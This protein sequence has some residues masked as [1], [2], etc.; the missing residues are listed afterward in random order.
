[1]ASQMMTLNQQVKNE[2][3]PRE[4]TMKVKQLLAK[5]KVLNQDLMERIQGISS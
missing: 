3:I 5:S 4:Y 1:M 2:K